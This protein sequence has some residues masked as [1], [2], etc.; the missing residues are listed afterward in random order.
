MLLKFFQ[1]RSRFP[2]S[3]REVPKAVVDHLAS[4]LDVH[5]ASWNAYDQGGRTIKSHRSEIRRLLGSREATVANGEALVD[6]LRGHCLP[7][8]QRFEAI[9]SVAYERLRNLRIEPPTL[10]SCRRR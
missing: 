4:Q 10:E 8:T 2:R 5:P 3:A 1:S 9:E 7:Q 6:W